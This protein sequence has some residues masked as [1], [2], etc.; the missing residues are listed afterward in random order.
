MTICDVLRIVINECETKLHQKLE[1][2]EAGG[3]NSSDDDDE[4]DTKDGGRS[5]TDGNGEE[6]KDATDTDTDSGG[7]R[8]RTSSVVSFKSIAS[9]SSILE[10]NDIPVT[11]EANNATA[12]TDKEEGGKEFNTGRRTKLLTPMADE[13]ED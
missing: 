8:T 6:K 3:N 12:A 4:G 1:E 11:H 2:K 7:M 9:S 13:E 10:E 5:E